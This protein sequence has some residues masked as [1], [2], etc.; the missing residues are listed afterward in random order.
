MRRKQRQKWFLMEY[1]CSRA[2]LQASTHSWLSRKA[3]SHKREKRN[4]N[5]WWRCSCVGG[6]RRYVLRD[7]ARELIKSFE[8]SRYAKVAGAKFIR[9]PEWAKYLT[10]AHHGNDDEVAVATDLGIIF[11]FYHAWLSSSQ[12]LPALKGAILTT[13]ARESRWAVVVNSNMSRGFRKY[14]AREGPGSRLHVHKLGTLVH[15]VRGYKT[16]PQIF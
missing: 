13:S 6:T 5:C 15:H 16:L 4:N 11:F 1:K 3:A 9:P 10:N 12:A 7:R 8:A 2:P 14:L